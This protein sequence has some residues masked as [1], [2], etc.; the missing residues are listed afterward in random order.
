MP[1]NGEHL[2][3]LDGHGH[4]GKRVLRRALIAIAYVV[5]LQHVLS[6]VS[7]LSCNNSV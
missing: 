3:G 1:D 5:Q 2:S 4:A 6:S 7:S